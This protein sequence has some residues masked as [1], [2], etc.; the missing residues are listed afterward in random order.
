MPNNG[1]FCMGRLVSIA[2]SDRCNT[3]SRGYTR[4]CTDGY[5]LGMGKWFC[6]SSRHDDN[7][8]NY[9]INYV[10]DY[11]NYVD[12]DNNDDNSATQP[13]DYINNTSPPHRGRAC[14][15]WNV[16]ELKALNFEEFLET[17]FAK[18]AANT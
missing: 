13:T 15:Q 5:S 4:W 6:Y 1:N 14:A 11:D 2:A 16:L 9:N 3:G 18:F 7:H 12:D 17:V 10:N 8:N